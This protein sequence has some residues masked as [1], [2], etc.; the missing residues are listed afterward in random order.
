MVTL[1]QDLRYGIRALARTPGFAAIIILTLALGIGA[2]TAMFSVI[3][4]VLLRPLPYPEPDKI[5]QVSIRYNGQLDYSG[6]DAREFAFWKTHNQPFQYLAA[7]TGVGFNL[8]SGSQPLRVRA[9]RVS[10]DYFRVLGVQPIL[11][12][13]FT[14]D[15][16]GVSGTKVAILS[17]GLWKSQFASDASIVGK[18]ISLDSTPY[19][20]VGIMSSSFQSISLRGNSDKSVELWTTIAQVDHSIGGGRN[21]IVIG[22]IK[23]GVSLEQADSYLQ[24]AEGAFAKQL[25]SNFLIRNHASFSAEPLRSMVSFGYRTPLLVLFGAVGFVLLIACVNVA[26]LLMSRAAARGKE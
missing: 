15:E 1:W 20:V 25:G 16:D 10:K 2:N 19:T 4:G 24:I 13:E 22:R 21:Y 14:K 3:Y 23:P 9:L 7:T 18:T 11:G 6:F 5:V 12:R 17:Y 8:S 26:N